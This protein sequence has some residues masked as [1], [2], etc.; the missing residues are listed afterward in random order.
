MDSHGLDLNLLVA[1]HALSQ[2]RSVTGAGRKLGLSQ[3]AISYALA[4]LRR[5][6]GDPLFVRVGTRMQPT[7]RAQA[8][9]TAVERVLDLVNTEMLQ[10]VTFDPTKVHRTFTLC[11]SDIGESNFVSP[12]MERLMESA[13]GVDVRVRSLPPDQLEP[14][15]A[16]G[17][18]DLA[19][20]FFPDLRGAN[21]CKQMLYETEYVCIAR[22]GN[23]HVRGQ[24]TRHRFLAAPHVALNSGARSQGFIER[25]LRAAGIERRV[26][27][28]VQHFMSL[29]EV[30]ARTDLIAVV[31]VEAAQLLGR[32]IALEVHPLPYRT[33]RFAVR[34]YWHSLYDG[35]PAIQWIRGEIRALFQRT[36]AAAA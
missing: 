33:S 10:R 26:R 16:A 31:P 17:E 25:D 12:I 11:M 29:I 36:R 22:R 24:L 6:F 27:L 7:A 23:P 1:F 2:E 9:G 32:G 21:I 28:T 34:Q 30:L 19:V 8:L 20:G 15:L 35:D 4:R 5:I 14:S 3:P 18:I 13:P